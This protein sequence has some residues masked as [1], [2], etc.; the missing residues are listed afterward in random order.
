MEESALSREGWKRDQCILYLPETT[1]HDI[2]LDFEGHP[3]WEIEEGL[4]FLFGFIE[5][6]KRMEICHTG[7]TTKMKRKSKLPR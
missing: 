5:K 6:V 3:F 1:E 7:H 4:I 2:Y